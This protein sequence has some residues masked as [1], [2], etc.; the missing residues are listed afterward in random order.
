MGDAVMS[1]VLKKFDCLPPNLGASPAAILV[2][3]FDEGS[4]QASLSFAHLLRQASLPVACYPE[5]TKIGKQFKYA[6]RMG[7]RVVAVLGPDE[8]ANDQV[9]LKDL[10]TGEQQVLAQSLAAAAIR[11]ILDS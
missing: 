11:R 1:L 2:T 7:M 5:L 8:L 9:A 3:L 6:E 4:I 10:G